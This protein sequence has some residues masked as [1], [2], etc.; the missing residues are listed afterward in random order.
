MPLLP[1][2]LPP[3]FYKNG[4]PYTKRARWQDGSL[5]R[6]HLGSVRPIGG[7]QRRRDATN[8]AL[9]PLVGS[10]ETEVVRDAFAWSANDQSEQY[11]FGSNTGLYHM[12]SLGTV[13]NVTP[14]SAS[15]SLKDATN[16]SDGYGRG[17][18]GAGAYGV[19]NNLQG[20]RPVPPLRW[21]FA[22]F[23]Q[24]ALCLQRNDQAGNGYLYELDLT[25]KTLSQVTNA[26]T[27]AQAVLVTDQRQVLLLEGGSQPRRL[28]MS[29]VEDRTDWT[30]REANQAVDRVLAGTG[31]L[32]NAVNVLQQVLIVGENDA[33]VVSYIGPP[34]VVST[35]VAGNNCGLIAAEAIVAT[36]RFAFWLYDGSVQVLDCEVLDFLYDDIE[37]VQVSKIFSLANPDFT[38]IWWFYQSQGSTTGEVDSYVCWDYSDN[39]W[40]TGRL[41]RTAGIA[42]GVSTTP[43]MVDESGLIY[44]HEL[45]N[46][47]PEGDVFAETGPL[48]L[49]AGDMNMALR[50]IFSDTTSQGDVQ[51][52]VYG[53][54]FPNAGETVFG[55]YPEANPTATRAIGRSL[56]I[57][58]DFLRASAQLGVMRL[59]YAP[60]GGGFR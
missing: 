31:R 1:V 28:Q 22:N 15:M 18:Y 9:S 24:A 14:V 50:F 11:L 55:P 26:P 52:T 5:V 33:H 6:W 12:D 51:Y 32:L 48:D 20:L 49:K 19:A 40:A 10:A 46:V 3:G 8:V 13:T 54:Q 4:T 35:F 21:A 44:N 43:I 2:T 23:G 29:D 25:S 7:W 57:R 42:R 27:N 38:E 56:R 36:D 16:A 53:R 58:A 45:E 47:F 39:S 30:P 17:P 59:D 60:A 41:S 37:P 34:Y